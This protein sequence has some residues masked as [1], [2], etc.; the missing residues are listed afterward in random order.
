MIVMAVRRF[1]GARR[2][3]AGGFPTSAWRQTDV[4]AQRPE[5]D[6][7]LRPTP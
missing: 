3:I 2:H 7:N 6:S 1:Q 5:Q 4:V